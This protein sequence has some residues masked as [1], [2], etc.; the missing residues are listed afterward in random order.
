MEPVPVGSVVCSQ[1]HFLQEF[2]VQVHE[3]TMLRGRSPRYRAY[4][5]EALKRFAE[6]LRRQPRISDLS[7]AS[8]ELLTNRLTEAKLS[9][10]RI[11]KLVKPLRMMWKLAASMG[12]IAPPPRPAKKTSRPCKILPRRPGGPPKAPPLVGAPGTLVEFYYGT[13]EPQAIAERTPVHKSDVVRCLKR[14]RT[15][16]GRDLSLQ[17]LSGALVAQFMAWMRGQGL[18]PKTTQ[19]ERTRLLC[20]WRYANDVGQAPPIPRV[21]RLRIPREQPDAWSMAEVGRLIAASRQLQGMAGGLPINRVFPAMLLTCFYTGLRRGSLVAIEPAHVD[22][23]GRWLY[24]P[25]GSMKSFVGKRYRLGEDAVKAIQEIYDVER[26]YLFSIRSKFRASQL[27]RQLIKD[28]GIPPSRHPLCQFHKLRRTCATH[29]AVA[30]GL[31]AA[32][33]LLGH[34]S[35]QLLRYYIDP[36]YMVGNDATEWLRS[37]S[38]G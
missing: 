4:F 25:A 27:F 24:V 33:A 17:E 5:R 1:D 20:L 14:L 12:S 13:Y 36:S 26:P 32:S 2:L 11:R 19:T 9:R 23:A 29:V 21:P 30:G 10:E 37:P 35:A 31:A 22:L 28:A 8:L 38:V 18:A 3:P 6:A 16:F 15:C 34:S 7:L